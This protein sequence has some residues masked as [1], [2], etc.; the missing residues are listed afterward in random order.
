MKQLHIPARAVKIEQPSIKMCPCKVNKLLNIYQST[1]GFCRLYQVK[2]SRWLRPG[3]GDMS[4]R[5]A[6]YSHVKQVGGG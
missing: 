3:E 5:G 1:G 6:R 4:R 2:D